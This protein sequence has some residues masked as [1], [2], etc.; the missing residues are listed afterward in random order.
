MTT[1]SK[2]V[3]RAKQGRTGETP[4]DSST[5]TIAW[6]RIVL[7]APASWSLVAASGDERAGSIRVEQTG[8]DEGAVIVGIELRWS[9][10]KQA[11]TADML[12]KRIKP[13]LD[14]A[15]KTAKRIGADAGAAVAPYEDSRRLERDCVREFSWRADSAAIGRIWR[16]SE[17]GRLVIAQVHGRPGTRFRDRARAILGGIECH[18]IEV[19]WTRWALYGLDVSVPADFTL[20]A[21]QLMNIYIELRFTRGKGGKIGETLTVEQW[22]AAN[23]QLKGAYLDEWFETKG[24]AV[25][26][27]L[28]LDKVE[29]EI[30]GHP[31]L[32]MTGRR[33]GLM[34]WM[35]DASKSLAAMQLPASHYSAIGWECAA[36]NKVYLVQTLTV[37]KDEDTAREVAERIRCHAGGG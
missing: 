24:Q 4:S 34:Y 2:P 9:R 21:Q 10:I 27:S 8:P 13:L 33:T 35:G 5:Q 23:V 18:N 31:A 25:H 14:A 29:S 36:S 32:D 22:S 6:Q 17:C 30:H 20:T 15:E 1:K 37:R 26:Q 3:A 28:T 12:D 19:G 7:N 16:C 11:Q